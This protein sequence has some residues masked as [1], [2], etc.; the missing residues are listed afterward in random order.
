MSFKFRHLRVET[1]PRARAFADSSRAGRT[2]AV[3]EAGV[4][5]LQLILPAH[6]AHKQR[7]SG[8]RKAK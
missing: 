3:I 6:A 2:P 4:G 7:T 8:G 1:K 5:A